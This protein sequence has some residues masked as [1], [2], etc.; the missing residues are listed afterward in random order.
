MPHSS[1][2][3]SKFLFHVYESDCSLRKLCIEYVKRFHRKLTQ[4]IFSSK[5]APKSHLERRFATISFYLYKQ[6]MFLYATI[7]SNVLF[8]ALL[9]SPHGIFWTPCTEDVHRFL[10]DCWKK[11]IFKE[12]W[13]FFFYK[14]FLR[15]LLLSYHFVAWTPR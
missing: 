11:E 12:M 4:V 15:V 7:E 13:E 1:F 5:I 14:L 2:N 9:R 10:N 6:R 3:W 8:S